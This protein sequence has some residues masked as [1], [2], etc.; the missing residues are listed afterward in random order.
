MTSIQIILKGAGGSRKS[1]DLTIPD[2]AD[3]ATVKV[4]EDALAFGFTYVRQRAKMD[5]EQ[6]ISETDIA[7]EV[8][9]EH[10]HTQQQ[11]AA[12]QQVGTLSKEYA[13]RIQGDKDLNSKMDDVIARC[14]S[15]IQDVDII[16]THLSVVYQKLSAGHNGT[17]R[18]RQTLIHYVRP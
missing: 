16:K 9:G 13:E 18:L 3:E 7:C 6:S 15:T 12:V 10:E 17:V 2:G 14:T 1:L 8:P 4:Q 11:T 5:G